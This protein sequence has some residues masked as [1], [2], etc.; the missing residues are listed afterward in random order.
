MEYFFY[1]AWSPPEPIYNI[2][3]DVFGDLEIDWYYSDEGGGFC[4]TFGTREYVG[5]SHG[6]DCKCFNFF[7][8]AQF[9]EDE[10]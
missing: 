5:Q 6:Y 3:S 1:T 10:E 4:G 9:D 8:E 2:L 7:G